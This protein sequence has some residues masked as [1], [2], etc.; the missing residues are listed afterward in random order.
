[1]ASA[2][3]IVATHPSVPAKN[4]TELIKLA[5]AKPAQ[6]NYGAVPGNGAHL[7]TELLKSMAHIT[8]CTFRTK[9]PHPQPQISLPV[10][11]K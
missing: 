6:L 4:L 9:A 2:P 8:S 11:F 5:K 3:F 10:R 7:A 1:M